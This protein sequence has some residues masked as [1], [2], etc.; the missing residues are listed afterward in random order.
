MT[1]HRCVPQVASQSLVP[2]EPFVFVAAHSDVHF[3]RAFSGVS[4]SLPAPPLT[5][6]SAHVE[7]IECDSAWTS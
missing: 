4:W 1:F 6:R 2:L 5:R 3:S 7:I